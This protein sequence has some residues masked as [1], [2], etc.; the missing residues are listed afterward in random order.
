MRIHARNVFYPFYALPSSKA[1]FHIFNTFTPVQTVMTLTDA[2]MNQKRIRYTFGIHRKVETFRQRKD[3]MVSESQMLLA[4]HKLV[5]KEKSCIEIHF[6]LHIHISQVK[7]TLSAHL[8]TI[9][10]I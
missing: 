4:K 1:Y 3:K 7:Y 8:K 6:Y 5:R 2:K 10:H 9:C